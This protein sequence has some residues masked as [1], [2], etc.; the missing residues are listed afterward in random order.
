MIIFATIFLVACSSEA[1]ELKCSSTTIDDGQSVVIVGKLKKEV[2]WGPPSF[3]ESP[4]TDSKFTAWIIEKMQ[5]YVRNTGKPIRRMQIQAS[6]KSARLTPLDGKVVVAQGK[7][8]SATSQGDVTPVILVA[9]KVEEY[10][11]TLSASCQK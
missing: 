3:G 8:W 2:H 11:G 10:K 7:L 4:N 6:G 9:T 5:S 1:R